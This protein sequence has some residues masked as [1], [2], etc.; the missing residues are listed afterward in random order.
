M[1]ASMSPLSLFLGVLYGCIGLAAWQYGRRAQ[2][3][4]HMGLGAVLMGFGFFVADPATNA[5]VGAV[6]TL[7]LFWPR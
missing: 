4:R 7:L 5:V 6:L 2:R 3:A 1:L